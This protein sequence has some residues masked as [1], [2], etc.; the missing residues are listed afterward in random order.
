MT[1]TSDMISRNIAKL[2]EK[3]EDCE[4]Q[5]FIVR[6]E[7]EKIREQAG[8]LSPTNFKPEDIVVVSDEM[9]GAI[10]KPYIELKGDEIFIYTEGYARRGGPVGKNGWDRPVVISEAWGW[11]KGPVVLDRSC[12]KYIYRQIAGR[13]EKLMSATEVYS[14]LGKSLEIFVGNLEVAKSLGGLSDSFYLAAVRILK[15][16]GKI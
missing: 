6:Y 2:K 1:I 13:V 5:L 7:F 8:I 10:T 16:Q 12:F 15:E 4:G 11:K 14:S 3:M 9:V